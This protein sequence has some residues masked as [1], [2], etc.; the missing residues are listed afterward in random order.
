MQYLAVLI[1]SNDAT[2]VYTRAVS[3]SS[4]VDTFFTFDTNPAVFLLL[5]KPYSLS[6]VF[7]TDIKTRFSLDLHILFH[8]D[9]V[10]NLLE[11]IWKV[12]GTFKTDLWYL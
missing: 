6:R 12:F 2:F 4:D 9:F 5:A 1:R 8:T 3:I 7:S 11:S 10:L